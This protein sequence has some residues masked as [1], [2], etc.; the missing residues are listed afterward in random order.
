MTEWESQAE[1]E[2]AV[3]GVNAATG[4]GG[5]NPAASHPPTAAFFP[6]RPC[7]RSARTVLRRFLGQTAEPLEDRRFSKRKVRILKQGFGW[8]AEPYSQVDMSPDT[9]QFHRGT[10]L[11]A[12]CFRGRRSPT[13]E[14]LNTS[15]FALTFGII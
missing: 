12:S 7:N 2:S 3:L 4:K 10:E 9:S 1:S 15:R 11:C 14:F 8:R 5:L 6:I 13:R